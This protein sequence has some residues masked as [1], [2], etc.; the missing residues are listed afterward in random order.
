MQ[1]VAKPNTQMRSP[2]PAYLPLDALVLQWHHIALQT[3]EIFTDPSLPCWS[4]AFS[5]TIVMAMDGPCP[6][7]DGPCP[8]SCQH[9]GWR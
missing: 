5:A 7:M 6:A 9:A 4:R 3:G 2:S 8:I 1:S